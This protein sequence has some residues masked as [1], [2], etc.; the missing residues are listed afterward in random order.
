MP[1]PSECRHDFPPTVTRHLRRTRTFTT[2]GWTI[3]TCT[4][5][6]ICLQCNAV[7]E[8]VVSR[9]LEGVEDG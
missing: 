6:A 7:A 8:T 3:L 4:E 2:G 9:Q 1:Q 5:V